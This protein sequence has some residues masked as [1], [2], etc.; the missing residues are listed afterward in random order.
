MSDV[1]PPAAAQPPAGWYPDP[2]DATQ[3]RYW[4]GSA[5]TGHTAA[6]TARA[7][8]PIGAAAM[9]GAALPASVP[10]WQMPADGTDFPGQKKAWW[11]L[12]K[13]WIP[14][15]VVVVLIVLGVIGAVVGTDHSN[16]LENSI[17]KSGQEQLQADVDKAIPGATVDITKVHC[18]EQGSTQTYDC[19]VNFTLTANGTTQAYFQDVA[20]S[21]DSNDSCL[22]HTTGAPQETA[23]S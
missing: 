10:A 4:D 8:A 13:V 9:T 1:Q 21:C 19:L 11:K 20:G 2:S 18:V 17:K 3:Q 14:A 23:T 7:A 16:A 6:A 22:W 15:L 5:W 12:K